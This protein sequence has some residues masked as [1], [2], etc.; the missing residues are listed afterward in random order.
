M[1]NL[2]KEELENLDANDDG[3]LGAYA[4]SLELELEAYGSVLSPEDLEALD[5]DFDPITGEVG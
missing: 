3:G 4:D 1:D 5:G 2:S